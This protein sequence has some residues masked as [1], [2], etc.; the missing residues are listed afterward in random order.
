MCMTSVSFALVITAAVIILLAIILITRP[1]SFFL[2]SLVLGGMMI[3]SAFFFT[4]L[5]LK[6]IEDPVKYGVEWFEVLYFFWCFVILNGFAASLLFYNKRKNI[7]IILAI[8][9]LIISLLFAYTGRGNFEQITPI[10]G[11]LLAK[12]SIKFLWLSTNF[13]IACVMLLITAVF[14]LIATV[15]DW[16][17]TGNVSMK[18]FRYDFSSFGIF[19]LIML[20]PL[21]SIPL[22]GYYNKGDVARAKDYID[23]LKAASDKY[24]LE[25]GEYPKFVEKMLPEGKSPL[26]LARQEFFT[27]GVRGTYYFSRNDKYCFVFQN[28]SRKFGYYSITN[29][30]PWRFNTNT[31][32]YDN[33]FLNVCDES[34]KSYDDLISNHL[35]I[36]PEDEMVNRV[37]AET[38]Q[39]VQTPMS[40]VGSQILY[41]K[42]MEESKKDPSLVA[43]ILRQLTTPEPATD[44]K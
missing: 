7:F 15:L 22:G 6:Q 35:D 5:C 27:A 38:N 31:D 9:T 3:I 39:K 30:R 25:N 28:P 2:K 13:K 10:A 26:L 17:I 21:I 24:Y 20:I 23:K 12:F 34:M 37:T 18:H 8:F 32:S 41:D 19:C 16:T 33:A 1:F 14:S 44:K 29:S 11:G 40:N 42:I 4:D 36:N 43:P